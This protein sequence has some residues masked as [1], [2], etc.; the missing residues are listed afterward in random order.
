MKNQKGF[1]LFELVW[2]L[3]LFFI[4]VVFVGIIGTVS[5]VSYKAWK[6]NDNKSISVGINGIVTTRC[7]DGYTFVV[8]GDGSARQV[9]DEFGHGVRCER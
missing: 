7:V 3:V 4:V 9:T 5:Y 2:T 8:G 6:S 1:T